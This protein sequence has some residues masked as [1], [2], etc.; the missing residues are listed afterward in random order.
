MLRR[1]RTLVASKSVLDA[2]ILTNKLSLII[3]AVSYGYG[4]YFLYINPIPGDLGMVCDI[5][6]T[7]L[8]LVLCSLPLFY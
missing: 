6:L 4:L 3:Y 5:A 2:M 8:G 7:S 1:P